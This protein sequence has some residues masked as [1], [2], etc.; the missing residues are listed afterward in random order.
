[1]KTLHWEKKSWSGREY[2]IFSDGLP[3]GNLTFGNWYVYDAAY[4]STK[5]KFDFKT[6]GWFDQAVEILYNGEKIAVAHTS[7]LGNTRIQL[8]NGDNYIVESKTLSNNITIKDTEDKTCVMFE[9]PAF[10]FG[11]GTIMVANDLPELTSEM[12][13]STGLYLKTINE[14][15]VTI[16]VV[17]FLPMIMRMFN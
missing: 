7:V 2:N 11:K 10:S 15:K 16:M 17:I 8:S 3:E 9:Q 6:K 13:I 14:S 12:L 5:G 4:A 1:M